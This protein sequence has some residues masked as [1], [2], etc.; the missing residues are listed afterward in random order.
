MSRFAIGPQ[1]GQALQSPTYKI[2]RY[3]GV[4]SSAELA[5]GPVLLKRV[6]GQQRLTGILTIAGV[7]YTFSFA[8]T[9]GTNRPVTNA[10][11]MFPNTE[12]VYNHQI[13]YR[14][15]AQNTPPLG[16]TVVTQPIPSPGLGPGTS[17]IN[18]FNVTESVTGSGYVLRF[19]MCPFLNIDTT[20]EVVTTGPDAGPAIPEGATLVVYSEFFRVTPDLRTEG[21]L[22]SSMTPNYTTRVFTTS[23]PAVDGASPLDTPGTKINFRR[24]AG[25]QTI[26]FSSSSGYYFSLEVDY[27]IIGQANGYIG[28]TANPSANGGIVPTGKGIPNPSPAGTAV[29]NAIIS[30]ANSNSNAHVVKL[31]ITSPASDGGGRVYVIQLSPYAYTAIPPTISLKS[32]APLGDVDVTMKV[33]ARYFNYV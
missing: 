17:R 2:Y 29:A 11:P 6:T 13:N 3:S 25:Q 21:K 12:T 33:Y 4:Y 1:G 10:L 28:W 14:P 18:I 27:G 16:C 26:V 24:Y 8:L 9:G 22:I 7:A 32:G 23:I 30:S 31:E 19:S 15:D 5:D 20:I